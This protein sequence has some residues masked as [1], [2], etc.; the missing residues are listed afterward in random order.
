MNELFRYIEKENEKCKSHNIN[1]RG[2]GKDLVQRS[3][4][5]AEM[6]DGSTCRIHQQPF[7]FF[8]NESQCRL[9]LCNTCNTEQ[10]KG[11][12]VTDLIEEADR[13]KTSLLDMAMNAE[14]LARILDNEKQK[15]YVAE[16]EIKVQTKETI[17]QLD[18]RRDRLVEL[19]NSV[20]DNMKHEAIQQK[21]S[22]L[23]KMHDVVKTLDG[24]A[25]KFRDVA[26]ESLDSSEDSSFMDLIK[27][28]NAIQAQYKD[29]LQVVSAV[30]SEQIKFNH[31][32][33]KPLDE[34]SEDRYSHRLVGQLESGYI[35]VD[36]LKSSSIVS[37]FLGLIESARHNTDLSSARG[38][39]EVPIVL[40]AGS[41]MRS[42]S[43]TGA[44]YEMQHEEESPSSPVRRR[45]SHDHHQ[46]RDE[47]LKTFNTYLEPLQAYQCLVEDGTI[48]VSGCS[49]GIWWLKQFKDDGGFLWH[50]QVSS[51]PTGLSSFKIPQESIDGTLTPYLAVSY[52]QE[53]KI[54]FHSLEVKDEVAFTYD[55]PGQ[56]PGC[57][58]YNDHLKK[59]MYVDEATYPSALREVDIPEAGTF[60]RSMHLIITKSRNICG[61]CLMSK[62]HT[63]RDAGAEDGGDL[64]VI[65]SDGEKLCA[66]SYH[67]GSPAWQ[68]AGDVSSS[69]GAGMVY[70]I[71]PL[72]ICVVKHSTKSLVYVADCNN[73]SI[74]KVDKKG[75]VVKMWLTRGTNLGGPRQLTYDTTR[76][77]L[78]VLHVKADG[79]LHVNVY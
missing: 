10:H 46:S 43:V 28:H 79:R 19:I 48:I 75:K 60:R 13:C 41:L 7:L 37:R 54:D 20:I 33:F 23:L 59:L 12:V 64:L 65:L 42:D 61:L 2:D 52:K 22:E 57:L 8:C 11:H 27:D 17:F 6:P 55:I 74:L 40:A 78:F 72:G 14:K 44:G 45:E 70:N 5:S 77:Q 66:Y 73:R 32:E 62:T 63:D 9:F 50:K 34:H 24:G 31:L 30:L 68:L 76:S 4:L 67:D 47:C 53:N 15:V 35:H 36:F 1:L 16:E 38:P 49:A 39:Q 51:Q 56:D 18:Q 3:P 25:S 21:S 58:V 26:K 71:N 69:S 29:L